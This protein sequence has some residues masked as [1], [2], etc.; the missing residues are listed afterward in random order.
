MIKYDERVGDNEYR[1]RNVQ[2]IGWGRSDGRLEDA[3]HVV[4][5]VACRGA[6]KWRRSRIFNK[7][8]PV[9]ELPQLS[10]RI[11]IRF[12]L[13]DRSVFF[14]TDL[15]PATLE[16]HPGRTP[17]DR[18]S[19]DVIVDLRRFEKKGKPAVVNLIQDTNRRLVIGDKLGVDLGG[20]RIIKKNEE[21]FP[22]GVE[23][24]RRHP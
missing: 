11:A 12:E 23:W 18:I 3:D 2:L 9:H 6:N 5:D 8:I 24:R 21:C 15:G 1:I 17:Q 13:L 10:Q 20:R 19:A 7:R 16:I 14:D 4:V 22:R